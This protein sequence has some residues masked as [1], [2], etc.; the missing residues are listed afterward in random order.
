MTFNEPSDIGLLQ[1]L[2]SQG[3]GSLIFVIFYSLEKRE[4]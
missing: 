4:I 2:F 3:G 1:T